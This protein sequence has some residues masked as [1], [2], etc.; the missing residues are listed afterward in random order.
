VATPSED[1]VLSHLTRNS[2]YSTACAKQ[3]VLQVPQREAE[4][5]PRRRGRIGESRGSPGKV[6][7]RKGLNP[8]LRAERQFSRL[9]H[10]GI[11]NR[12]ETHQKRRWRV[13]LHE[14][15]GLLR[16]GR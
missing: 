11:V 8:P 2:K 3:N 13:D 9:A 6:F 5:A 14:K 10:A 4:E 12:W 1:E 7:A 15:P 16:H